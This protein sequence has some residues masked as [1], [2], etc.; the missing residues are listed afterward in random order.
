MQWLS[1]NK[2]KSFLMCGS[3]FVKLVGLVMFVRL[4]QLNLKHCCLLIQ[5]LLMQQ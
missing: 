3:S 5:R 4:L 2:Q 1:G